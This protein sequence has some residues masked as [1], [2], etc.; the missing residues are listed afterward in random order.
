MLQTIVG[1]EG[2]LL[3]H[4]FFWSFCH[5]GT[6]DYDKTLGETGILSNR[7]LKRL[8]FIRTQHPIYSFAVWGKDARYLA[9][10]NNVDAFAHDSPF[11][12]MYQKNAV[13]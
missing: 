3:F 13:C 1:A 6:F 11:E 8:D 4:T 7:A 10:L 12:Y 5:G 9:A 2:T